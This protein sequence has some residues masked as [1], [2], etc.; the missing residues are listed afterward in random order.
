MD[1][2][3]WYFRAYARK[4]IRENWTDLPLCAPVAFNFPERLMIYCFL[5]L[6][7]IPPW[8]ENT[9]IDLAGPCW[10]KWLIWFDL[11]PFPYTGEWWLS[12]HWMGHWTYLI[13][14]EFKRAVAS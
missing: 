3:P 14:R 8:L 4:L 10:R 9:M 13:K 6:K 12:V 7:R 1:K 11:S 5:V 2:Y